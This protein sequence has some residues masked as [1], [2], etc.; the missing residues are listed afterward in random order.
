[1]KQKIRVAVIHKKSYNYFQP[2]H[3]DRTTYD[4]FVT[5]LKTN[6]N[7]EMSYFPTEK[8]F[9]VNKLK[10]RF[11]IILLT[12]NDID[13]TPDE[14]I[15]IEKLEIPIISRTGDSHYAKLHK[16][17]ENHKKWKI[18]YYFGVIP[19]SYFHK[20]YPKDFKYREIIFG[21]EPRLY[22]NLK[23]YNER[24]K[25]KILNTGVMGNKRIK[26]RI[27]N[28]LFNK[29]FSGWNIYK[30]RTLCNELPYVHYKGMKDGKY[31]FESSFATYLSQ[32]RASIAACTVYPVQKYWEI[33]AAGCL[34]FMEMTERNNGKYLGFRDNETAIF[35]NERNYKKKFEL[36]LS[37]PDNKLYKEIIEA[38]QQHVMNNLTNEHATENL[39]NLMREL[40]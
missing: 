24:I 9:D 34:A 11:D 4:F 5:R 12:N 32:F 26:S 10:S 19:D 23:P 16:Q 21:L 17:I 33:P 40:I 38:G 18:D 3:H 36:F 13:A 20:Y 28:K 39:I 8:S 14:L 30:L 27:A 15:G 1:M 31:P 37:D 29:G 6:S 22:Q 2:D 7:L 25:E 35:I